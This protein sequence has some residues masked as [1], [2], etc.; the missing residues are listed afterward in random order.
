MRHLTAFCAFIGGAAAG[1]A[2][3][4]L[5]APDRG[6]DTRDRIAKLLKDKGVRLE[7][8]EMKELVDKIAEHVHPKE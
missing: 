5:F 2:M 4:V 8:G 3:G 1:A 7:S 6:V